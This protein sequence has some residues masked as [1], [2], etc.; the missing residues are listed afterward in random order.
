MAKLF[1]RPAIEI[2]KFSGNPTEYNRFKRQFN[3]RISS[4]CDDDDE[5]LSYLEQYTTGDA[6]K[7]VRGFSNLPA[8]LGFSAAMTELDTRY[9]DPNVVSQAYIDRIASW[10]S[11]KIDDTKAFDDFSVFL[12]ECLYSIDIVKGLGV[13]NYQ[14]NLKLVVQ[15]I[16]YVLHDR[17]RSEVRRVKKSEPCVM[18][19]HVVEF[20]RKEAENQRDSVFGRDALKQSR[21]TVAKA[22]SFATN[23]EQKSKKKAKENKNNSSVTNGQVEQNTDTANTVNMATGT[24]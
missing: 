24:P 17:W 4:I 13:L 5:R 2:S 19:K 7:I 8:S 20:V 10:S 21:Q 9:G 6:K 16:P 3:A 11:F 18:F 22:K 15:K 23:V 14:E 12:T 1:K